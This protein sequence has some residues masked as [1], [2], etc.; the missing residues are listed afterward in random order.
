MSK[1]KEEAKVDEAKEAQSPEAPLMSDDELQEALGTRP[2]VSVTPT[3]LESRV[4]LSQIDYTRI[5]ETTTVCTITLPS[6]YTVNGISACVNVENFDEEIGKKIAYENAFKELWPL[7]GFLL[8]EI[9][10]LPRLELEPI[11]KK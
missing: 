5:G 11:E 10:G 7:Y 3:F 8:A 2:A 1:K 6:G 4:S 9:G